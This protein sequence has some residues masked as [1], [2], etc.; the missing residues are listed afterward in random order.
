MTFDVERKMD[1]AVPASSRLLDASCRL[2][3]LL[4]SKLHLAK[5]FQGDAWLRT[6][7]LAWE[8]GREPGNLC[9]LKWWK[10][11]KFTQVHKQ[12]ERRKAPRNWTGAVR[13]GLLPQVFSGDGGGSAV[14][15]TSIHCVSR[16]PSNRCDNQ[17]APDTV[18]G[19]MSTSALVENYS[20]EG[21][22]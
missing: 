14:A 20:P 18:N 3:N 16:I 21:R 4:L 7:S 5:G 19:T 15:L 2:A 9:L 10:I 12:R 11:F 22:G 1:L 6:D 17:V 13:A 8:G